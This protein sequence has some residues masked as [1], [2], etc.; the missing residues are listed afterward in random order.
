[1]KNYVTCTLTA[2]FPIT[3]THC[4]SGTGQHI[5][6]DVIFDQLSQGRP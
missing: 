4:Y 3:A 2:R 6:P 5:V 1:M